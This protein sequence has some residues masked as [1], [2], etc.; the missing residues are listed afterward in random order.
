METQVG[1]SFPIL[2]V[3]SESLKLSSCKMDSKTS[4]AN[5]LA[6]S[7][8]SC[9]HFQKSPSCQWE[10]SE[11]PKTSLDINFNSFSEHCYLSAWIEIGWSKC[12]TQATKRMKGC[13]EVA[14][15]AYLFGVFFSRRENWYLCTILLTVLVHRF[16]NPRPDG[17]RLLTRSF[18]SVK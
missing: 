16:S 9:T 18:T 4:I 11:S 6:K 2:L 5:F 15:V 3:V 1:K 17:V 14:H 7:V 8:L 12:D 13:V 10:I